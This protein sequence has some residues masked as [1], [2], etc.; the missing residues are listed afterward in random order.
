MCSDSIGFLLK[1]RDHD[2]CIENSKPFKEWFW[3]LPLPLLE[4]VHASLWDGLEVGAIH[5]SQSP[6]CNVVVLV[7]KKDGT[8]HFCVN[9]RCLNA[10]T[11][12]DLYTLPHR[13]HQRRTTIAPSWSFLC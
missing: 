1:P 5:P 7:R 12:K 10:R 6:W 13:P 3:Q 2:I 9:F 8:L 11:K 4:E